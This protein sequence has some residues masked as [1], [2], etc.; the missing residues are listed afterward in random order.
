M[1]SWRR[2]VFDTSALVSAALRVGSTPHRVV[3]KSLAVGQICVS[4][5]TLAE[6]ELVLARPKF[7]RYQ[8][9]DVRLAFFALV[10]QHAVCFDVTAAH[11]IQATPPCRDPKDDPFLA[12]CIACDADA[13]VSSDEDLLVL[14][15]WNGMPILKPADFETL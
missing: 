14:H 11:K 13:L 5:Y 3:A 1:N 15:P 9:P 10:R 7:D 4:V 12:L 2:V 6:L 8:L